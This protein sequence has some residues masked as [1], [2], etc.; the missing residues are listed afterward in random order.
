MSFSLIN[1]KRL[2]SDHVTKLG[3]LTVTLLK[4]HFS[5]EDRTSSLT[6]DSAGE[7]THATP[8]TKHPANGRAT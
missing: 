1:Y 6:E 7:N 5:Y 8:A 2:P 4:K 3:P